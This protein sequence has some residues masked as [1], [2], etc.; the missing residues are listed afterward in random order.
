MITFGLNRLNPRWITSVR[1]T[2]TPEHLYQV[3]VRTL[4]GREYTE[5]YDSILAAEN[6]LNIVMVAMKENS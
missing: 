4:D 3:R 6:I 5:T 1:I 2:Q